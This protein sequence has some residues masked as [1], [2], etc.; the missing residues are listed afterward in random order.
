[1]DGTTF[2]RLSRRALLQYGGAALLLGA[3]GLRPSTVLGQQVIGDVGCGAGG[4]DFP[5]SPLILNPFTD[6][7]IVPRALAP[8]PR[9]QV[10]TWPS[11]PSPWNQDSLGNAHQF[12]P[13]ELGLKAPIYYRLK[14]QVREHR[15]TSSL[16][17]PIDEFG[18]EVGHPLTQVRGPQALPASTIY[19]FNGTFPGP[20][21]NAQYGRPVCVRFENELD[22]NPYNLGRSDFGSPEWLSLVHLHN[23]HTAPESDGNPHYSRSYIGKGGYRPGQWVDNMYLNHPPDGDPAEKQSFLWFHDHTEDHTGANVYKGCVAVYPIY[24]PVKDSGNEKDTTGLQLPGVRTDRADGAFDVAYDV[25]LTLADFALDDGVV[26]HRDQHNGCGEAHPDWWGKTFFRHYPN[27]GFVGDVFTVNGTAYPVLEVKRR[28]Y[29]FRILCASVARNYDLALMSSTS[30]PVA[31]RET[32][33]TGL[34]LQGQY[35]LPDGEQSMRFTQIATDGG[36]MPFAIVRDT[37]QLAPAK[38]REVIVD[39]TRYLDGTPTTPGDVV[40]LVNTLQMTEGRQ[41]SQPD[42]ADFDPNYRV[43][44]L[45][46]VIGELAQDDSIMPG[47]AKKLRNVPSLPAN[48]ATLPKR[49][50]ILSRANGSTNEMQWLINGVIF[51]PLAPLARVPSGSAEVWTFI[52][53]SGGWVHPLHIHQEEHRVRRRNG[54]AAPTTGNPDDI[55]REDVIAMAPGEEVEI[56][57]R[58]RTFTGSYVVHCHNLAHEDHSMMF[59]FTIE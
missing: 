13:S 52:N 6:P 38:R 26:G 2:N 10:N 51:D 36:L 19:G 24:D 15:F 41:E 3:S 56:V 40:Y 42:D 48:L 55:S 50:F 47:P 33:R 23:A 14:T 53:D 11:P 5:T 27:K 30:S 28:K 21:I 37:I 57:R 58:F 35:Q 44:L 7:L 49:Q 46:F 22:M 45:K 34:G 4:E 54:V 25:P 31:S 8:I 9:A 12:W 16:V 32:G 18:L 39:F 29:R 20:M 1:M 17:L 59:G 43:P